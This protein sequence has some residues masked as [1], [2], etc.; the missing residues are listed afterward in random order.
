MVIYVVSFWRDRHLFGLWVAALV[1]SP[2][3]FGYQLTHHTAVSVGIVLSFGMSSMS[4]VFG[5]LF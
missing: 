3:E 1:R 2:A 5:V 4:F